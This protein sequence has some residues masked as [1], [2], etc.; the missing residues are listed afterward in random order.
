MKEDINNLLI[1]IEEKHNVRIHLADTSV[2]VEKAR[3]LQHLAPTSLAALGRVLSITAV[4]GCMLK[5]Q[6]EVV[7]TTI[8]GGG[9][10]GTILA[11]GK[12]NGQV[13]GFV[14]NPDCHELYPGTSKLAVGPSVG[15][16]GTLSVSK[17]LELK[18]RY[19]TKV[20]LQT[21]EIGDDFA[22][23]FAKSEQR[24]SIVS[25]G[26][27]VDADYK[28]KA[29][30]VFFIELLPGYKEEDISYLEDI[31][32]SLRPI[33][34]LIASQSLKEILQTYFPLARVLEERHLE[35]S[36]DCSHLR[37]KDGLRTLPLEE[38][39]A[40]SLEGKAEVRCDFCQKVY[41]F[42]NSEL[43]ELIKNAKY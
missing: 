43:N 18:Q 29:A 5:G 16:N 42:D 20:A 6:Q 32:K 22:F 12:S 30:G 26:V 37:F 4:M 34:S 9:E 33:S 35:Y 10:L 17:D 19:T 28:T 23:Y 11:V 7:T 40:L 41:Y 36:C 39:K 3:I 25:L 15:C 1:A 21:G 2:L 24:P 8:N 14:A 31:C 27:L 38:L 13:K